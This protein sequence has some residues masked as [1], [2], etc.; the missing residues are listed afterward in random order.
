MI[1]KPAR[2]R[3]D[4]A[5][6]TP[7]SAASHP[8]SRAGSLTGRSACEICGLS[9]DVLDHL[10]ADIREAE[11]AAGIAIG[12]LLV[13]ESEEVEHCGVQVVDVHRLLNRAVTEFIGR[14][15]NMAAFDA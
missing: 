3:S 2:R 5:V 12:Q 13:V 7:P 8:N 1:T 4:M 11:V 9:D 14:A 15:V 6:R 10:P